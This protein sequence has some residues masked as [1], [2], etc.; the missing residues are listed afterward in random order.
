[1][2]TKTICL[3]ASRA[4]AFV[5]HRRSSGRGEAF[6]CPMISGRKV[7][8]MKTAKRNGAVKATTNGVA[9][10]TRQK[11]SPDSIQQ[12]NAKL[13]AKGLS[14]VRRRDDDGRSLWADHDRLV[15]NDGKGVRDV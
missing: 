12:R 6:C 15:L 14:M 11:P 1:M 3:T 7:R 13:E 4:V 8:Q 5:S 10:P 9:K 2:T